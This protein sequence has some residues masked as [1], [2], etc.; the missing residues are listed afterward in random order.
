MVFT[1]RQLR[2]RGIRRRAEEVE[3][4]A[5]RF[6]RALLAA[7]PVGRGKL[8]PSEEFSE[9]EA[10]ALREDGLDL[11]AA[12]PLEADVLSSTAARHAAML[13]TA[14]TT[15]AA[16]DLLGVGESRIRQRLQ[17]GTLYRVKVGMDNRLPLFQ[18]AE[19]GEVPNVG[20]VIRALSPGLHPVAIQNWFTGK[21]PDLN[22]EGGEPLSPRDW[23]LVGGSPDTLVAQAREL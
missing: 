4:E 16:A 11:S 7:M 10:R 17:Q 14:L 13:A 5:G 21:N 12:D 8:E 22:L 19:G 18:F 1:E 23:L 3:E 9:S 20:K 2:D 6:A 15:R